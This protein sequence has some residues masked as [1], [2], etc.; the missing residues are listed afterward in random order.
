MINPAEEYQN[1][2]DVELVELS[3]A[4]PDFFQFIISRYQESLF[5]Y[6]K[7]IGNFS[8]EDVEDILQE[9]F[10]KIYRNLNDYDTSLKFSSWIYRITHN[11]TVDYIRKNAKK[12]GDVSIEYNDLINFLKSSVSPERDIVS[13]DCIDHVRRV[14]DELPLKYREVLILRFMEDKDYEEIVDILK[15]PKGTIAT[16]INRGR[17]MLID[18]LKKNGIECN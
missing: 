12:S 14:I 8:Q 11:Q 7:R 17:K 13:Q 9:V 15:K 2:S 5:R 4:N 16:L 10:V 3:K 18:E 6:A 1:K